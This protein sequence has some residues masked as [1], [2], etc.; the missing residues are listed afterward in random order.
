MWCHFLLLMPV[1]GLALFLFLPWPLAL[2]GYVPIA[3]ASA[4]IYRKSA[5]AMRLPVQTGQET[6]LGAT[7]EVID[8]AKP[9][10][11]ASHLVRCRGEIW[12]V[13]ARE[14]LQ[15]GDRVRFSGFDGGWPVVE[16]LADYAGAGRVA[17]TKCH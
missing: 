5:E 12:S 4:L 13:W 8:L 6:L 11:V 14:P 17:A 15:A 9:G 3:A 1:G 2:A 7:G 16:R 10:G